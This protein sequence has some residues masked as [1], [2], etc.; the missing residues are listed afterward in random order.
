[1]KTVLLLLLAFGSSPA[2]AQTTSAV[3]LAPLCMSVLEQSDINIAG[4]HGRLCACVARET[5]KRLSPAEI[6]LVAQAALQSTAPPNATLSK[7][8]FI[9][10]QCL[11]EVQ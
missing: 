5:P 3:P 1:M 10:A 4:D 7:V 9:A 2:W 8:F 11:Q 6:M